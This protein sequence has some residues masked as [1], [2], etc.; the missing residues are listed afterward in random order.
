[1]S[2]DGESLALRVTPHGIV[3]ACS[4]AGRERWAGGVVSRFAEH[5]AAG[6]VA[7]ATARVPSDR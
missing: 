6:L 2:R 3:A 4:Y 5:E 1:M 7:L